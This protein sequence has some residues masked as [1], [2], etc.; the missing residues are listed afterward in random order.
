MIRYYTYYSC[1]G[2]KDIY[3]GSDQDSADASYFIPLLNVWEKSNKPE[4]AVKIARAESVKHIELI[5]KN[6]SAGFPSECNRM[7]SHGGYSAIYRTLM[8]GRVCL[9]VRD[10]PNGTKDEE[11]RDIPFN[12]MFLADGQESIKKLDSLAL[13]YLSRS[14]DINE[15]IANAISYDYIINGIKFDLTKLNALLSTDFKNSAG[16]HHQTGTVDY[17]K[18][19]SRNYVS[20]ALREQNL[21]NNMVKSAWDSRGIFH[22]SLQYI[23]K[24][25]DET[26]KGQS[27][28]LPKDTSLIGHTAWADEETPPE[29]SVDVREANDTAD[30]EIN[31]TQKDN[32][33]PEFTEDTKENASGAALEN[34]IASDVSSIIES[35]SRKFEQELSSLAKTEDIETIKAS[36]EKM[37]T[38]NSSAFKSILSILN[39]LQEQS[40][41]I[42][43]NIQNASHTKSH[44]IFYA[45]ATGCL[46]VGF[47]LGALIF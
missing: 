28:Q 3:I 40:A 27:E 38:D 30:T 13:E 35:H 26:I 6:N 23:Q 7:F 47:I 22:G 8:D 19:A 18:I 37:S 12:F 44:N 17:L 32:V 36:L 16:L 42:S 15:L 39:N 21:D 9:C 33:L 4:N 10:I 43:A 24:H 2:Y 31:E 5:S 34:L 45:I 14:N 1:G 41:T 29:N 46:I 11:G 20:M 25:R